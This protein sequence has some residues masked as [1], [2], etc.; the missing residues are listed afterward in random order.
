[1]RKSIVI[2]ATTL[3]SVGLVLGAAFVVVAQGSDRPERAAQAST[4][5]SVVGESEGESRS[6]GGGQAGRQVITTGSTDTSAQ[7]APA[8]GSRPHQSGTQL[9]GDPTEDIRFGRD[10]E[11]GITAKESSLAVTSTLS[12]TIYV[13]SGV[14]D[15]GAKG[16]GSRT[17]ATAVHCSNFGTTDALVEVQFYQFDGT[18]VY[19]G[20]TTIDVNRTWTFSSQNTSIYTDDVIVGGGSGT[21]AIAQGFG[22]VLAAHTDIICTAQLLD[23]L[24]NPP[25]YIT[26][27]TMVKP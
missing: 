20:S 9:I 22:R 1:M 23:P 6:E 3:V 11:A 4:G 13:F 15:D 18:T 24:N 25:T 16:S 10:R 26:S 7:E 17:E 12:E 14:N 8:E 27:L 21:D 2:I 19:T 5:R